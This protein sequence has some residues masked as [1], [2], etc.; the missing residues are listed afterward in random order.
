MAEPVSPI[1]PPEAARRPALLEAHGDRRIDPYFWLRQRANPEVIAYLDDENA[2][3]DMV[4]A[5]TRPLQE[6]IYREITSRIKQSDT[7]APSFFKGYWHYTRTVEGLNYEI[8]CRRRGSMDAPEEVELDGNA[9]ADGHEYFELGYVERSPD[10]NMLAYAVDFSGKELHGLRFRDLSTGE[11]LDDVIESVYYGGAW[12][13]DSKTFFYVRPD[14]AM[15]PYQVW[16]HV[17]GTPEEDDALV[18][19]EDDERFE[20]N[21]ELTKSEKFVILSS[22]SQM[23]SECRYLRADKPQAEPVMIEPRRPGVEYSVDHQGDRFVILTNDGA[24]NFRLVAAPFNSPGKESWTEIVPERRGVR[25][26][27]TDVHSNHVVLGQRSDGLQRLEVL[28]CRTGQLHVVEQPDQAYTAFAGSHP[29]YDSAVMRFFYTSLTAPWTALDYNMDTGERTV[30]KQQPVGG[31]YNRDD[32]VTDRVWATSHDGVKVPMS[33][34][35]R[36]DVP[37]DGSS[38]ALLYGYGAYEMPSDPMF[39]AAR[40][41][42][43]DRGFVY[44]IAHVRGGGEM[45][46]EWYEDGKFLNKAN[47]FKDFIACARELIAKGHRQRVRGVGR[48][49]RRRVLR[50][51]QDVLALRKHQAGQLP[52]AARD[53]RAQRPARPVLGAREMGREAAH[54]RAGGAPD[55]AEDA[56]GLRAFGTVGSLRVVA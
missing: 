5:G 56:H 8:H 32:Y 15:R 51:H 9:L 45:G 16:R 21:V 55:P 31:E 24:R 38:P 27:A 26:N 52:R 46:R 43:L 2:Y 41:S 30:V 6:R 25:L 17:L 39:D 11:D 42:L 40:L 54:R 14:G 1:L 22:T 37:R 28:H 23:T 49:Q 36:R 4:M 18:L 33:I 13:A 3:A 7:S 53:R 20:L 44:A 48:P 10:E 35:H 19:Q 34:V 47:T 12:A 50:V 29:D